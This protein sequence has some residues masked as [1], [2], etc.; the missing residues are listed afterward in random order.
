[1]TVDSEFALP[2]FLWMVLIFVGVPTMISAGII[3][4]IWRSE[5]TRPE[6]SSNRS[7]ATQPAGGGPLGLWTTGLVAF[8]LGLLS[9]VGWLSWS[10][11]YRGEFR[12]PG[13][14]APTQFPTWQVVACG[15]T[16]ILACFVAA[17]F[18]RWTTAGGFA[19][20]VG[21]T[22]GFTTAFSVAASTDATGQAGVGVVLS[23]LGWG[24][25]LSVLMLLRGIWVNRQRD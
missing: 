8:L 3:S 9:C 21:T 23:A 19:A 16:V 11:D 17:H 6:Q 7:A 5:R 4:S 15:I 14:P 10:V 22:A 13:L 1:M 12:R 2:Q 24:A 18:S 20:A 25:C